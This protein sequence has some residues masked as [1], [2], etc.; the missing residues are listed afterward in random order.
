[1]IS[2]SEVFDDFVFATTQILYDF[3]GFRFVISA[4]IFLE[5]GTS[6]D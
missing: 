4:W 1:M 6:L 3:D 2:D 5:N